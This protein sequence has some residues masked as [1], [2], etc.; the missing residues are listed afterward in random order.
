MKTHMIFLLDDRVFRGS[1]KIDDKIQASI[2]TCTTIIFPAHSASFSPDVGNSPNS[3][4]NEVLK[5]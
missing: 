2:I 4:K 3:S 5:M 1:Q